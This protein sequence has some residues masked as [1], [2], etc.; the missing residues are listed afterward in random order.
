M[1]LQ[2]VP[3]F[4]EE[5]FNNKFV[6]ILATII[7]IIGLFG[8]GIIDFIGAG[9]LLSEVTGISFSLMII[10]FTLAIMVFTVLG[11]MYGVIVTDTVMFFTMLA[12]SILIAPLLI[13]QAGFDAMKN[14][15]ETIPG[16]WTLGGTENRSITWSISQFLVWILFF[17][18]IPAH[19]S[20]LF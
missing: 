18:V 9:L 1:K 20:R 12:V 7:M 14:L 6:S 11:G 8:Y 10:M 17:S 2:T 15:S 4:F 13:G 3:E 16:Y 5:R 19:I